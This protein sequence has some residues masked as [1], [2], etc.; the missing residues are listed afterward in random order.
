MDDGKCVMEVSAGPIINP[1]DDTRISV[2][3]VMEEHLVSKVT[4]ELLELQGK[5]QVDTAYSVEEAYNELKLG[6]YDAIV[7]DYQMPGKDGLQVL[8]EL[9]QS[10][11][12]VPFILF[13]GKGR[14]E[15]AVEALN[16]GADRARANIRIIIESYSE[17]E[18]ARFLICTP[19]KTCR[20]RLFSET[21]G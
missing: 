14:E 8:K 15:V 7:S 17:S 6:K 21:I 1:T 4:K 3:Y 19:H 20:Y 12:I 5:F 10:G 16:L 18:Y 11:N 9:R 13:T 2:L